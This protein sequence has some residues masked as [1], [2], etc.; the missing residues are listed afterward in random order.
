MP[1]WARRCHIW[2]VQLPIFEFIL[3]WRLALP[4]SRESAIEVLLN[5]WFSLLGSISAC[6]YPI[7]I[8]FRLYEQSFC[9]P[10]KQKTFCPYAFH[11]RRMIHIFTFGVC[12]AGML[13]NGY[14]MMLS[15]FDEVSKKLPVS[16]CDMIVVSSSPIQG[17]IFRLPV[18]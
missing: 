7:L 15:F 14:S 2:I 13:P 10:Y 11:M 12:L 16:D 5:R 3:L 6:A 17:K 1:A 8:S 4:Q 9:R 18:S